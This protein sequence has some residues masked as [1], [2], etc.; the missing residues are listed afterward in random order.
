MQDAISIVAAGAIGLDVQAQTG[1]GIGQALLGGGVGKSVLREAAGKF[2]GRPEQACG[3]RLLQHGERALCLLG[4]R[5]QVGQT[6]AGEAVAEEGVECFF[7]LLEVLPHFL[8]HVDEHVALGLAHAGGFHF[9]GRQVAA[10]DEREQA[11]TL[12]GGAGSEIIVQHVFALHGVL[13]EEQCGSHFEVGLLA[14]GILALAADVGSCTEGVEQGGQAAFGKHRHLRL[15]VRKLVLELCELVCLAFDRAMPAVARSL[16]TVLQGVEHRPHPCEG[17]GIEQ[18]PAGEV[19]VEPEGVAHFGGAAIEGFALGDEEQRVAQQA[20]GHLGRAFHQATHLQ[21]DAGKQL[22]H[23][24]IG[25]HTVRDQAVDETDRGPPEGLCRLRGRDAFNCHQ[26][27]PHLDQTLFGPGVAE[28]R[29]QATL[30]NRAGGFHFGCQRF[31]AQFVRCGLAGTAHAQVREEQLAFED[32]FRALQ[33][34]QV[35]VERKQREFA[36]AAPIGQIL[37]PALQAFD[38][39]AQGAQ[40]GVIGREAVFVDVGEAAFECAGERGCA[41]KADHAQGTRHLVRIVTRQSQ[42]VGQVG[43]DAV[44]LDAAQCGLQGGIDVAAYPV[45]GAG[46]VVE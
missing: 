25:F 6:V 38:G 33:F 45:E 7:H 23:V 8:R 28:K 44:G 12:V 30:E 1:E 36:T 3:I 20:L 18:A 5:G 16:E 32:A 27:F 29:Q 21:V 46:V 11:R 17:F 19:T 39:V 41:F 15:H 31:L 13:D 4:Q 14:R 40:Q 34:T 2:G 43:I 9:G 26:R 24:E 35:P 37:D 22:L 10:L 42:G